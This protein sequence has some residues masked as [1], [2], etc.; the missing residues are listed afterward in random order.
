[1]HLVLGG[2][3]LMP[4]YLLALF[5]VGTTGAAADQAGGVV[6]A[7]AVFVLVLPGVALAGA[8]VPAVRSLEAVAARDLLGVPIDDVRAATSWASRWRTAAWFTLHLALGSVLSGLSLALPAGALWLV[9]WSFV[10]V[11]ERVPFGV[12]AGLAPVTG[13]VVLLVFGYLV[14]GVVRLLTLLAPPLL[15]PT[16]EDRVLALEHEAQRLAERN[17]LAR[18]LHDSVGHAL[19]IITVQAGAAARVQGHDAAFVGDALGHIEEAARSALDDLDHVLGVLRADADA[20][21]P[22]AGTGTG[23]RRPQPTLADLERL[24]AST[25]AAGASVSLAVEGPLAGVPPVVSRE[26]YRIV[27]E[28]LTNA[29]RHAG[30][31]VP[32]SLSLSVGAEVLSIDVTNRSDGP[33]AVA[34]AGPERRRSGGGRGLAGIRER[35]TV[36]RGDMAAG[37]EGGVWRLQVSL[38]LRSPR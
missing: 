22:G 28:G 1:V 38:P 25:V 18:E 5:V 34:A 24:V 2:A 4:F 32:V 21:G 12:P 36:L 33:D 8:L 6:W 30:P 19:S 9:A 27:Q 13:V 11:P 23:D 14:A 7:V 35:V 26:A 15:G 31:A 17:R 29:L 20:T 3:L 37:A 10:A 16:P